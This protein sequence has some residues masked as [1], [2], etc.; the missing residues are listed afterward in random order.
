MNI[1]ILD[2]EKFFI[3][4][5]Y[6][7]SHAFEKIRFIVDHEPME[8]GF[9]GSVSHNPNSEIYVITDVFITKQ[10]RSATT[11]EQ[12]A[13]GL[14]ELTSSIIQDNT[15]TNAQK[16]QRLNSLNFWG[17]S[18][19]D[20]T[21]SPSGQDLSNALTFKTKP[22]LIAAI[23]NKRG[24]IRVDFYDF[25]HGIAYEDLE[26]QTKWNLPDETIT[27]ILEDIR[28]KVSEI[29]PKASYYSIGGWN[30][31]SYMDKVDESRNCN[32]WGHP[33]DNALDKDYQKPNCDEGVILKQPEEA[34]EIGKLTNKEFFKK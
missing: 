4:K 8:I 1:K 17:H 26:V 32:H 34:R 14:N 11:T 33:F 18:H 3:P 23:F 21:V 7:D 29:K 2:T 22:Y 16:K 20:M 13:E 31:P 9:M 6:I 10:E 28:T 30:T 12:S 15:L 24:D 19:V 25:E 27:E 5:V